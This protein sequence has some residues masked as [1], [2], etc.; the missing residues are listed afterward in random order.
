MPYLLAVGKVCLER[1]YLTTRTEV[2]I[3]RSAQEIL[4]V[5]PIVIEFSRKAVEDNV[6]PLTKPIVGVSGKV[7]KELPVLAG[8]RIFISTFGHHLCVRPS[9][10]HSVGTA[11]VEISSLFHRNKDLWGPDAHEFRPERWFDAIK[12]ESPVGV[13]SNLCVICFHIHR[14]YRGLSALI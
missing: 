7:Y 3:P 11:G 1:V 13:Y 9:D 6:L 14:L 12:H 5:Y 8:T 4:R 2:L 10:P